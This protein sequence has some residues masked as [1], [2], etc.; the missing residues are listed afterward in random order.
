MGAIFW[1]LGGLAGAWGLFEGWRHRRE[2]W[3]LLCCIVY[4]CK[5]CGADTTSETRCCVECWM[6]GKN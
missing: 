1:A 3:A 6:K 4:A 2:I 5:Y